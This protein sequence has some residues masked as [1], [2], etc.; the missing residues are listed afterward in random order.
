M[1]KKSR[2]FCSVGAAVDSMR[3]LFCDFMPQVC[4]G[5]DGTPYLLSKFDSKLSAGTTPFDYYSGTHCYWR[6]LPPN[7]FTDFVTVHIK[8]NTLKNTECF[9]ING[10]TLL[11]AWNETACEEGVEYEFSYYSQSPD[12]EIFVVTYATYTDEER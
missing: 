12:S 9:L 8:F 5:G 11:T 7:D 3:Y 2:P 4:L 10:G 6:I 1:L